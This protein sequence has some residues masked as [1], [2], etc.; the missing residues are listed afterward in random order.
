MRRR[1]LPVAGP[2]L[3]V[4]SLAFMLPVATSPNALVFAGGKVRVSDLIRVGLWMN[5]IGIAV[6]FFFLRE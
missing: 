3:L 4:V 1:V 5:L 6:I 2:L